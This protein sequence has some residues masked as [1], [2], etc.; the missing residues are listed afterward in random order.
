M[1]PN[2]GP[3]RWGCACILVTAEIWSWRNDGC[4]VSVGCQCRQIKK[5]AHVRTLGQTY[6]CHTTRRRLRSGHIDPAELGAT[7][8]KGAPRLQGVWDH[9]DS[10]D[11]EP[12]VTRMPRC[13][14]IIFRDSLARQVRKSISE[15]FSARRGRD[16]YDGLVQSAPMLTSRGGLEKW[17]A[18]ED[19]N[20]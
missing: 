4:D 19:S 11:A 13:F 10:S 20:L 7:H 5:M 8:D 14:I 2:P 3:R 12:N 18:R 15:E 17:Y 16:N 6:A 1:P 9:M